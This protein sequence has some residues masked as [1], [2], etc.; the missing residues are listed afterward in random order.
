MD[1]TVKNR[2]NMAFLKPESIKIAEE[3][4]KS[5]LFFAMNS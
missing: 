1:K 3:S 2:H 5:P 4:I